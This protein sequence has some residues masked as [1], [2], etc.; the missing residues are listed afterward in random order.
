MEQNHVRLLHRNVN[1]DLSGSNDMGARHI[2]ILR[3]LVP[4]PPEG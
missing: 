3:H 2:R 1:L 4:P